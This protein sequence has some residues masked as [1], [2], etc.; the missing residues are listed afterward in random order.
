MVTRSQL[1]QLLE[2]HRQPRDGLSRAKHEELLQ[3]CISLGIQISEGNTKPDKATASRCKVK[4]QTPS[5]ASETRSTENA[6]GLTPFWNKPCQEASQKL[7]LPTEIGWPGSPLNCSKGT[8]ASVESDSWFT[9]KEFQPRESLHNRS[10]LTLSSQSS[11]SSTAKSTAAASTRKR[12]IKKAPKKDAKPKKPSPNVS[13]KVRV[14]PDAS[15]RSELMKW[16]GG[17]RK[18]YN[19]A[20]SE[21]KNP[22]KKLSWW[23]EYLLKNR[24]VTKCNI[25]KK[26]AFL[27]ED[28]PKHVREGAIK[29]LVL[30]F[31]TNVA[32]RKI[33]PRHNWT[34]SCRSKKDDQAIVIPLTVLNIVQ[35]QTSLVNTQRT[36][37]MYP[38]YLSGALFYH[39]KSLGDV[40]FEHDCR[41]SL[42]KLN[43]FYLHIPY[44]KAGDSQA[45]KTDKCV[46][47][48]PGVRTFMTGYSP[49]GTA[50]SLG[51]KDV[52]RVQRLCQHLDDLIFKKETAP[53]NRRWRLQRA[54]VHARERIRNLVTEVHCK[55][56]RYLI[57]NYST[58]L[59][60]EF[61]VSQM[62]KRGA[63]KITR[64]TVR[65]ML[66]W[67]H[68]DFRQ[69]LLTSGIRDN[70]NIVV[71]T[72]EYT[73]KT[74]TN[75]GV[76]HQ[77]LGGNKKF[78]CKTCG[79]KIDRDMNGARNIYLKN[80]V[81][82]EVTSA[83]SAALPR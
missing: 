17:V 72:E 83:A 11:T 81:A 18:T 10:L 37:K 35:R 33:N 62:V 2:P 76:L 44:V 24:F 5:A 73:S 75:C 38:S 69:R 23:K 49:Q 65:Q 43:R 46:A 68:Y 53:V 80:I 51:D 74:C 36:L 42:D 40:R 31:K 60:P 56:V 32:K 20:L 71:C 50:F 66:T 4:S 25:P 64:K 6:R 34:V 47:L 19:W 16:F 39:V 8:F 30:A 14:R 52:S 78:A 63:R 61:N 41:L 9:I 67:R 57:R 21:L 28:T 27:H 82:Q 45:C 3:K 29:D 13:L 48:D 22:H 7:W 15:V 54:V 59:I 55:S 26:Y 1:L 79:C 70:V 77:T 58:I 12:S